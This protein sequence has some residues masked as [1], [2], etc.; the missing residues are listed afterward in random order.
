MSTEENHTHNSN[1][2]DVHDK[3]PSVPLIKTTPSSKFNQ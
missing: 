2:K 1:L 3:N